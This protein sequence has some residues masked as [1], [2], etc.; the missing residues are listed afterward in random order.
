M[1]IHSLECYHS[2]NSK[3]NVIIMKCKMKSAIITRKDPP[4]EYILGETI[5][6]LTLSDEAGESN[7]QNVQSCYQGKNEIK[8][9]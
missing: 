4:L 1:K 5:R 9:K 8:A 6:Y 2:L 3:L 7:T